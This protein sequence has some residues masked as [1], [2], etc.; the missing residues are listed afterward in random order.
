MDALRLSLC[1]VSN[2]GLLCGS[3]SKGLHFEGEMLTGC[4]FIVMKFCLLNSVVPGRDL[5]PYCLSPY[6][7]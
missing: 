5:A 7:Q 2:P 6:L 4:N 1:C 3:L